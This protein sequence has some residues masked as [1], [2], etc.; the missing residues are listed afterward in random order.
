MHENMIYHVLRAPVNL[1]FDTTPIGR[2]LNKFSSDLNEIEVE[3]MYQIGMIFAFASSTVQSIVVVM[4]VIPWIAFLIPILVFV[5]YLI[6]T[7]VLSAIRETV[8]LQSTCKSPMLSFLSES[9]S[10]QSTIRAFKK[11]GQF[12]DGFDKLLNKLILSQL[13][14]TSVQVWF[15]LRIDLFALLLMSTLVV[16]CIIVRDY[17]DPIFLSIVVTQVLT[18]PDN[19]MWFFKIFVLMESKMVKA[20]RCMKLLEIPIEK[21]QSAAGYDQILNQRSSWPENGQIEF[22]NVSLKYRP[23][24]E[25][26]LK[27]LS[28]EV[29]SGQ[30]VG[31]VGRTGAGKSTICL[32]ISRIVE[33]FEGSI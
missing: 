31:I 20:D 3:I 7:R 4:I 11:K 1:Y 14:E 6:I 26:V 33:L 13:M 21:L 12:I 5:G 10:G 29:K 23:D 2:I 28:F 18:I 22:R 24:T 19:F 32:A 8:R 16:T 30:K 27:N 15:A 17:G 9:I 25:L